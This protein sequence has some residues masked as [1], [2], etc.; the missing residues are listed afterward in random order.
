MEIAPDVVVNIKN[1]IHGRKFD[2]TASELKNLE[3]IAFGK[4][5]EST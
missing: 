2:P 4:P 1:V 3:Y 5:G